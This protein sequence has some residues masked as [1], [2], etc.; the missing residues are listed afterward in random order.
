MATTA[1][2]MPT[3]AHHH[4]DER[5]TEPLLR[6]L[7]RTQRELLASFERRIGMSGGRA[8]ILIHLGRDGELSQADLERRLGIDG[9]AVTRQVKA[10]EADELV[11]RR[12]DPADNRFTL[13]ALTAP[14]A[15]LAASLLDHRRAF[16]EHVTAGIPP[17]DLA[18]TRRVLAQLVANAAAP[19]VQSDPRA[20]PARARRQVGE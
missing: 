1:A 16:E 4:H 15:R 19:P 10:L 12:A 11:T 18:L 17:A 7:S 6:Q 2:P 13:V 14:G 8:G 9:A 5:T 3:D 20:T